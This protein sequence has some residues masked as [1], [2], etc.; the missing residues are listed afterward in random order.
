VLR[1]HGDFQGEA[2]A[3]DGENEGEERAAA[4]LGGGQLGRAG[5]RLRARLKVQAQPGRRGTLQ[6][7]DRIGEESGEV[8]H[9]QWSFRDRQ[10]TALG[11]LHRDPS[12]LL[13]TVYV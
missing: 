4:R 13:M 1:G 8:R 12:Y 3:G 6:T 2:P 10:R 11:Q 5:G 7:P 9:P